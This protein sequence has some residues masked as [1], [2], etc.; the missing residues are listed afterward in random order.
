VARLVVLLQRPAHLDPEESEAWLRGRTAALAGAG[1]LR[2]ATLSPLRDASGRWPSGWDWLIELE[3]ADADEA[4]R[5]M[6]G[7]PCAVLLGD[8]RLLGLRPALALADASV[9]VRA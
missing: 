6:R 3:Y 8:L 7:E 4:R 1:G 5:A 9:A 2:R